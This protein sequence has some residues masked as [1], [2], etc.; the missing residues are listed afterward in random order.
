MNGFSCMNR[1]KSVVCTGLGED[2]LDHIMHI[3]IDGPS[4]DNFD[5]EKFV[6]DCIEFDVTSRHNGHN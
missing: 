2:T 3:N 6:S 5:S 1:E 4:L